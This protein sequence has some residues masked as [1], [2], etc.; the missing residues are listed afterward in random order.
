[1]K[2]MKKKLLN[3]FFKLNVLKTKEIFPREK[4]RQND[5]PNHVPQEMGNNFP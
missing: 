2:W 3:N 1:M 5:N 4:T